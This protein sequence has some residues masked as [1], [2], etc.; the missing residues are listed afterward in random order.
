MTDSAPPP[1][2]AR[3]MMQYD[4]HKKSLAVAYILWFVL[5]MLGA[6]RFY[7]GATGSGAAILLLTLT[8][9][10]LSVVG[11]GLI[12]MLVPGVWV[13]VDAFLIPG[14]VRDQNVRLAQQLAA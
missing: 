9:V 2:D 4:A 7:S 13:L 8:S 11:I 10:M 3:L 14:M 6:H 1:N 5:G 12:L